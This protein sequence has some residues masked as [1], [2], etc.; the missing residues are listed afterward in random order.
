MHRGLPECV[1]LLFALLLLSGCGEPPWNNPHPEN[2]AGKITYQS[3]ISPRPPKHLDPARSYASD[4]ALFISQITEPPM[5]YHF[6][7]R[8]Y[9]LI[10]GAL[11]DFPE[12]SYVDADGEPVAGTDE[13][14]AFSYYTLRL[15]PD[16]RY[17]PHPAFALDAAGAPLYLFT[18]AREGA[19][20]PGLPDFPA[21]ATRAVHANDL[22]YAIKRLAD[23][24]IGSPM[25]GFM[26]QYIHGMKEFT[27]HLSGLDRA[28]WLNLDD[29]PMAGLEVVDATTLRIQVIGRYPQFVYWLAMP[30]FSPIPME[31]D[32]FFHNPGFVERNLTLDWW[33]MG[34]GPFMMVRNDPN[35]EIILERNPNYHEDFFPDTGAPGDA[36]QG[37]LADAGKRIPFIDRAVYRIEKESLSLWTKFMQGYYDRS[38]EVHAHTT[39]YYDASF[40]VGPDGISMSEELQ[41]KGLTM[42]PDVKPGLYYYAFNMRDPVVGGYTED[43]RKLR[44]ALQIAFDTEEYLNIFYKGNA[45]AAQTLI[46]PGIPGYV[47]G[48]A[49]INPYVYEWA[50][51]EPVRK[52]LDEARRLL[53]EAGYPNGR[54][55]RT[56][57]P[58]KLFF[59]VQSQAISKT[60]MNWMDRVFDEVGVQI[61]Y[62]QAD[63]NRTREKLLT[64]NTQVFS[65]G[66]LADYPDPE[67]FLFLLYGPESPLVCK[68]D[69]ANPANYEND[70]FDELFRRMRVLPP[71]AEREE[72]VARMVEMWRRDAVWLYAYYPKEIFL[73]NSWVYN[74]KRH[75][76]S[77]A[78]LKYVRIDDAER[79]RL[80]REWNQPVT[81]PLYAGGAL[82]MG[83]VLPG[84]IAYRRRQNETASQGE[85]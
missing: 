17:A 56:G 32:R 41:S 14:V 3:M 85:S 15:R 63:W 31:V 23:P 81:W 82:F 10:P 73:N 75:G 55:A 48:E 45:I 38:G 76:I 6:L 53:A 47:E 84:V 18:S 64:G 67:N 11:V 66:W 77:K 62:R 51:G 4:E 71:G 8:P 25:L 79:E 37:F 65:F 83:L 28:G 20:Y 34:S 30:F 57:E 1:S 39:G 19:R 7:K 27:E 33:P 5:T 44:R 9:E 26:A 58:L 61:E 50:D 68:C 22:A 54:D 46:P 35:S 42:S 70:A 29:Y 59:D 49:G 24:A 60:S 78:T 74:T 12:V 13:R 2:P 40:V 72:L 52:S 69:G 21:T 80:R 16:L 43:K 36:E